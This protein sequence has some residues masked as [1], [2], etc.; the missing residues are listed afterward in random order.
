MTIKP[1]I[2]RYKR[3]VLLEKT[4]LSGFPAVNGKFKD[5]TSSRR[6]IY[7]LFKSVFQKAYLILDAST[8][9]ASE[10]IPDVAYYILYVHTL[11][12]DLEDS[13]YLRKCTALP[14]L[15]RKIKLGIT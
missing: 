3:G 5:V 6:G 9:S 2:A 15:Q 14:I 11:Q 4:D 1:S 7:E 10:Y 8:L 13:F 12:E